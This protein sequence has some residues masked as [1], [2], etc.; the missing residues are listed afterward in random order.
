M[1]DADLID[2][3]AA[4]IETSHRP[5]GVRGSLHCLRVWKSVPAPGLGEVAA[6]CVR[7]QIPMVPSAP[8]HF[9]VELWD[10]RPAEVGDADVARIC[11]HLAAYRA[12]YDAILEDAEVQGR[13]RMHRLTVQANLVGSSIAGSP[14]IDVL[15]LHGREVAF[16]T[17]RRGNGL[18]EFVPHWSET[19]A[20]APSPLGTMLDHLPWG[21]PPLQVQAVNDRG[22]DVPTL[23]A[24]A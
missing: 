4:W 3:L 1:K 9:I 11:G 8:E 20:A 13:R 23:P 24:T 12:W 5:A 19:Q 17:W 7:H 6:V 16:W 10:L 21:A 2:Q 18:V 22:A 15:S 14:L